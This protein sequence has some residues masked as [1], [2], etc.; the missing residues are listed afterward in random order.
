MLNES[1]TVRNLEIMINSDFANNFTDD[2]S[3][4]LMGIQ[5][6]ESSV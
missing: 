2:S 4:K 1:S 6:S 5:N 3:I